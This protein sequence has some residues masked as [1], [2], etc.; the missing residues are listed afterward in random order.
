MGGVRV[1]RLDRCHP[2]AGGNKWFKLCL[3]LQRARAQGH[4]RLLSFGGPWSNHLH[5]LAGLGAAAGFETVGVVRGEATAEPTA[6]L[7]DCAARGMALVHVSRGDYRR[8]HDAAFQRALLDRHGPAA[9]I[10]EGGDC[11][12]GARGCLPVGRAI[13][14]A[15]PEGATVVV[16][17]GTGTTLAGMAAA[18]GP[19]YSLLG[20]SALKGALD[21]DDRVRRNL[22]ALGGGAG[23]DWR[24]VHDAH[25]GG[26][27]RVSAPLRE[28]QQ[29]AEIA[30][31]LP[32]DPVYTAK[33]LLA[34]WRMLARG[35]IDRERPVVF[36]HTGGLQG[37]RG[38]AWL[39][40]GAG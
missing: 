36:V 2:L 24:I 13:A 29:W 6:T 39:A 4:R 9:L 28:F 12:E 18:L 16:P 3:L 25:E 15:C 27:A 17:A 33:A 7:R 40:D 26:F 14:G 23:A 10:P 5:A 22:A 8:R 38:F 34:L 20:I 30:L 19:G 11:V 32:L 35:D 21:T 31:G 37:R 1:L